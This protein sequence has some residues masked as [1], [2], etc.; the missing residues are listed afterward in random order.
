VKCDKMGIIWCDLMW[1]VWRNL[2]WGGV[3]EY[4]LARN[5]IGLLLLLGWWSNLVERIIHIFSCM[6]NTTNTAPKVGVFWSSILW[7]M[8]NMLKMFYLTE[9]GVDAC[10]HVSCPPLFFHEESPLREEY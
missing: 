8:F 10:M 6:C 4:S 3:L 2:Q 1:C 5:F 7:C 9:V